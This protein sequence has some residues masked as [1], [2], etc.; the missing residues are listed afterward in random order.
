M[1]DK[2]G[3]EF[4]RIKKNDNLYILEISASIPVCYQSIQIF[5]IT[6]D[7]LNLDKLNMFF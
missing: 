2:R 4:C 1:Q 6:Q 5:R 7:L 3:F